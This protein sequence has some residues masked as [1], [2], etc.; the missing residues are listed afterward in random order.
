MRNLM[1]LLL[2]AFILFSC[3]KKDNDQPVPANI[4]TYN[5]NG[6]IEGQM[7]G[8]SYSGTPLNESFKFTA[9][10]Y[11][12]GQ[13]SYFVNSNGNYVCQLYRF[14]PVQNS[15]ISLIFSLSPTNQ[16]T[17]DTVN[18][19][20]QYYKNLGN[21]NLLNYYTLPGDIPSINI[22]NC[23]LDNTG[24]LK[25]NYI[26]TVQMY[27]GVQ[28]ESTNITGDFNVTLWKEVYKKKK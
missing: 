17:S 22:Y 14:D 24:Q 6:Y 3:K 10:N 11:I 13:S 12:D 8:N 20:I 28:N 18:A 2:I 5:T 15:S 25:G 7:I 26:L 21:N 16:I 19:T 23:S 9:Y 27:N 1:G 4:T